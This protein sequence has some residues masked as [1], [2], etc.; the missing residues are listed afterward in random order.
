MNP[1]DIFITGSLAFVRGHT[2]LQKYPIIYGADILQFMSFLTLTCKCCLF[3]EEKVS[4]CSFLHT[5][6]VVSHNQLRCWYG[7]GRCQNWYPRELQ[8]S[9]Q[10]IIS[11]PLNKLD[12]HR[13]FKVKG[14]CAQLS[15]GNI[16]SLTLL[17]FSK[18]RI[19]IDIFSSISLYKTVSFHI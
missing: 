3:P 16:W 8:K 18:F 7:R 6:L 15:L 10:S 14:H 9:L 13:C 1:L 17:P 4:C 2:G 11:S 12:L 19:Y 5:R